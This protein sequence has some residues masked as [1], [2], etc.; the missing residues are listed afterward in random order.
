MSEEW[1]LINNTFMRRISNRRP[2]VHH[3][4]QLQLSHLLCFIY[5]LF[6]V[7]RL[8]CFANLMPQQ[9]TRLLTL[10]MFTFTSE[11]GRA[12]TNLDNNESNI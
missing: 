8:S 4:R 3:A 12:L 1:V 2:L 6:A 7:A 10:I 9:I 5:E 11:Y